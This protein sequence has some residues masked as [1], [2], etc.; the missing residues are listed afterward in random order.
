MKSTGT[1]GRINAET[2]AQKKLKDAI[3]ATNKATADL[4]RESERAEE[5]RARDSERRRVASLSFID[6]QTAQ[7]NSLKGITV[8]VFDEARRA[9]VLFDDVLSQADKD[10]IS[11]NARTIQ[12]LKNA[13]TLK[14]A[15][16]NIALTPG[17][18]GTAGTELPLIAAI[19]GEDAPEAETRFAGFRE[20]LELVGGAVADLAFGVGDLVQQWVLLG[21]TGPNAMRKLTASVL[22]GLA[23]QA[24]VKAIF[25]LAEGFAAL[26]FNP[27]AAAAHFQSAALFGSIAGV[28]AVAGRSVAGDLFKPSQAGGVGRSGGAPA[29]LQTITQ[30]RNQRADIQ[31]LE[32]RITTND[33][34]F[35]RAITAH[36]VRNIGDG[37]EI[38]E[39]IANDGRAA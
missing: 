18:G 15:L 23:A 28:A 12:L 6:Q 9:L 4:N 10:L 24:A 1:A 2:E 30:G 39:V 5:E 16:D 37:G 22:A 32:I 11:A 35:G 29:P 34:E 14:E 27:A 21:E 8:S 13:E 31:P 25:Q 26:F 33:S 19:L 7:I 3:N 36:V 38:R 20:S 17:P